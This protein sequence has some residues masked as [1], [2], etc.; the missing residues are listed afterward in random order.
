MASVIRASDWVRR[1]ATIIQN[2]PGF[3]N[4]GGRD[5]PDILGG[6]ADANIKCWPR[7]IIAEPDVCTVKSA[8]YQ[9]AYHG[10]RV[11]AVYHAWLGLTLIGLAIKLF[12]SRGLSVQK[13]CKRPPYRIWWPPREMPQPRSGWLLVW[14]HNDIHA[15]ASWVLDERYVVDAT[16]KRSETSFESLHW[17]WNTAIRLVGGRA[18]QR[19]E[20]AMPCHAMPCMADGVTPPQNE[21]DQTR[22][23]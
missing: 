13:S 11:E 3:W 12:R 1:D 15:C 17:R 8:G 16:S 20:A 4:A 22:D 21:I 5:H 23:E 19:R 2:H 6:S 7:T 14:V 18:G 9:F 10:K